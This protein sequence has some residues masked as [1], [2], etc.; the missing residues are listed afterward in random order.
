MINKLLSC[1]KI[2]T[3]RV[4]LVLHSYSFKPGD[5]VKGHFKLDGGWMTYEIKRVECDLIMANSEDRPVFIE[6]VTTLL[7]SQVMKPSDS[8]EIPFHY[9]I[10]SNALPSSEGASY[11]LQTRVVFEDNYK[12]FD[13]DELFIT[14]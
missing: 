2:G 12:T 4:D 8:K 3:P 13:H 1:L 6:P 7:T 5:R 11:R 9:Q 10:P 14:T